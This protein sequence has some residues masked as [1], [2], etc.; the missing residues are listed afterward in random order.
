M[1][2]QITP[3]FRND[4]DFGIS[5]SPESS[6]IFDSRNDQ[7]EEQRETLVR[8]GL[9]NK[10]PEVLDV[11]VVEDRLKFM[12]EYADVPIRKLPKK[13]KENF[14]VLVGMVRAFNPIPD[15][16]ER[17]RGVVKGVF[18]EDPN[19]AKLGTVSAYF[20]GCE[21]SIQMD[22]SGCSMSCVQSMPLGVQKGDGDGVCESTVFTAFREK[23]KYKFLPVSK[24][25]NN[26]RAIVYIQEDNLDGFTEADKIFLEKNGVKDVNII[27]FHVDGDG[28]D[29]Y[30][31]ITK[32]YMKA[33]DIEVKPVGA[34]AKTQKKAT[35]RDTL[36]LKHRKSK[37]SAVTKKDSDSDE[38]VKVVPSKEVFSKSEGNSNG[39][40]IAVL[41][42]LLFIL[43]FFFFKEK[44]KNNDKLW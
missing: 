36:D 35:E 4:V 38:T 33:R 24:G 31:E 40:W 44:K 15:E 11:K 43:A 1:A 2:T 23:G 37:A 39:F 3:V 12:K 29:V 9:P 13:A 6:T 20:L 8:K 41:L 26:G 25:E 10:D 16:Y 28:K 18:N 32:G 22:P 27:H 30:K 7:V 34:S 21:K 42:I 17:F 14:D 19:T 5:F